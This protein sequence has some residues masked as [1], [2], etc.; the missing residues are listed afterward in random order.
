MHIKQRID[1]YRHHF[2]AIYACGH[3]GYERK[4]IGYYD[5]HFHNDF[6]PDMKC[7]KCGKTERE[8][9]A[10]HIPAHVVL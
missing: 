5:R 2:I 4:G 6:I 7:P 8:S 1:L 9:S 3:C 10:A